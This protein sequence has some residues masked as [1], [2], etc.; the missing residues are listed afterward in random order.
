MYEYDV[1]YEINH[2]IWNAKNIDIF[3]IFFYTRCN[4]EIFNFGRKV[5][6]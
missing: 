4:L 1:A 5:D 6:N 2:V 3:S